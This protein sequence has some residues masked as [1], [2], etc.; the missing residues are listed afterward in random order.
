MYVCLCVNNIKEETCVV[1]G[2]ER[3]GFITERQK[4]QEEEKELKVK[5]SIP[6]TIIHFL[7]FS[8]KY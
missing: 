6:I 8:F 2:E 1:E 5:A 3:R 7:S 4:V